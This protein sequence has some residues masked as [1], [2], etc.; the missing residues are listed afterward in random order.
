M[1]KRAP[2]AAP[3]AQTEDPPRQETALQETA[4]RIVSNKPEEPARRIRPPARKQKTETT[5]PTEVVESDPPNGEI[6][7]FSLEDTDDFLSVLYYG[8][9][10]TRK[11]TNACL[12]TSLAGT[13]RVLVINA[14]A[15]LKKTALQRQGVDVS[16]LAFW[17]GPGQQVTFEGLEKLFYQ[18]VRDLDRDPKA[19]LGVVWDSATDIHQ[20]LLDQVVEKAMAQQQA[21]I[22]RNKGAR[23]GNIRLRERFDN[24]RDDY[25]QMSNQFRLLLRRYRY[26]PCHFA[27]TA[28][29]RKDEEGK[30]AVYGPAVTPA[31]QSDLLG[32]VDI[33]AYTQ[34][35]EFPA[36]P[37]GFAQT[38][39]DKTHRAKDRYGVLPIELPN[40]SFDRLAAYVTG[41][42][43]TTNDPD[44]GLLDPEVAKRAQ[45][46]SAPKP[47]HAASVTSETPKPR[48]ARNVARRA[49]GKKPA[50]ADPVSSSADDDKPPF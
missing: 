5:T 3:P 48:S 2:I 47:E 8:A 34:V 21:I 35:A 30:S 41:D 18:L 44:L 46:D 49:S 20:A 17:P 10:G 38:S 16:R 39:P 31:I 14:E 7:L 15:G 19:W 28:L 9:E 24:D 33:V 32:Y 42:L 25:R 4:F 40:A 13:G 6:E 27:V 22:D 45:T 29:L 36:G 12:M 37:V 50:T 43:C 26:L 23:P 11:T 1:P